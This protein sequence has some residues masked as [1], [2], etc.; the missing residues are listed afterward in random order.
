MTLIIS[1]HGFCKEDVA[2]G[3]QNLFDICWQISNWPG[4]GNAKVKRTLSF[5]IKCITSEQSDTEL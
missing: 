1:A 5:P 2:G 3:D 4:A